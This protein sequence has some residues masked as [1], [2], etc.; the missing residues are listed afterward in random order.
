MGK[1]SD[2]EKIPVAKESNLPPFRFR[3]RR[4]LHQ[5][6]D[7]VKDVAD[8]IFVI[9]E[10]RGENS[11]QFGEFGGKLFVFG[12]RLPHFHES[13][14]DENAHL[15]GARTVQ[16]IGGHNCAVFSESDW[17]FATTTTSF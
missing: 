17:K 10:P 14:N 1:V 12:E 4:R 15:D 8:G 5:L 16:N 11:F 3:F 7:F 13:A 6:F 9:I 2:M